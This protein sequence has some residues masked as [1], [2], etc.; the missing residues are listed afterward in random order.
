MELVFDT[1]DNHGQRQNAH[2]TANPIIT[3]SDD[4]DEAR[5]Q[6]EEGKKF[7]RNWGRWLDVIFKNVTL[8]NFTKT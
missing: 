7:N 3:K 4:E 2:K 1:R 8:T 6:P 5:S